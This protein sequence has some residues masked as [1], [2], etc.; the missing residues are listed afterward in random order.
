MAPALDEDTILRVLGFCDASKLLHA[1]SLHRS[2]WIGLVAD[3]TSRAMLDALP[4]DVLRAAST[5]DLYAEIKRVVCGPETWR[6]GRGLATPPEASAPLRVVTFAPPRAGNSS[7]F[8]DLLPGGRYIA[9][10]DNDSEVLEIWSIAETRCLWSRNFGDRRIMLH[11]LDGGSLLVLSTTYADNYS[12]TVSMWNLIQVDLETGIDD[13]LCSIDMGGGIYETDVFDG[14]VVSVVQYDA[15]PPSLLIVNWRTSEFTSLQR[16]ASLVT[17]IKPRI[18]IADAHLLIVDGPATEDSLRLRVYSLKAIPT[19]LWLPLANLSPSSLVDFGSDSRV[20]PQVI[21]LVSSGPARDINFIAFN[22]LRSPVMED[23]YIG[24][25]YISRTTPPTGAKGTARFSKVIPGGFLARISLPIAPATRRESSASATL[26]TFSCSFNKLPSDDNNT[27]AAAEPLRFRVLSTH[28][29]IPELKATLTD[30]QLSLSDYMLGGSFY[31]FDIRT[32]AP[33][34]GSA[35]QLVRDLRLRDLP[36]PATPAT[37]SR[38]TS[39]WRRFTSKALKPEPEMQKHD[40]DLYIK[41][42]A[43]AGEKEWL[44]TYGRMSHCPRG[45]LIWVGAQGEFEIVYYR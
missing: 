31:T 18:Q 9:L 15:E 42:P 12:E 6:R 30:H 22:L 3:L 7:R 29:T 39:V 21:P 23:A 8:G 32:G 10:D 19:D 17:S 28:R 33:V 44:T 14:F 36:V 41:P 13:A 40:H 5:E 26:L 11:L 45:V 20:V 25:V 43:P 35:A 27:N 38:S 1:L 4:D 2:V 34:P 37:D 16:G 24:K